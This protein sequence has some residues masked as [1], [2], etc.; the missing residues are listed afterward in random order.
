MAG[1]PEEFIEELKQRNNIV[2]VISRYMPLEKKGRNYWGRCPFHLE[3]T[4]SFSV[5]EVDQFYHCFGCKAGGNL[6]KFVMEMESISFIE[7]I[8][9]VAGWSGME[10]PVDEKDRELVIRQKKEREEMLACMKECAKHYHENLLKS[11]VALEYL[12]NRGIDK[13]MITKFGI[14]FANGYTEIMEHLE[15]KGYKKDMLYRLGIIKEKDG[16]FYDSIGDRIAFPIINMYGEVV[17]FSGRTMKKQVDY[18]K[19]INTGDTPIFSKSKNLFGINLVKKA[20]QTGNL[21]EVIIVEGQTDVIAMHRAGYAGTVASLGTALTVDQ[22]RIIKRLCDNVIICY[23]G[24][25]AGAKATLRGLDILKHENLNVRVASIP[26]NMDP[27]ELLRTQGTR[28]VDRVIEQSIPLVEYKLMVLKNKHNLKEFDGKAKYVE[29][30]INVLQGLDD[31]EA[32]VYIDLIADTTGVYKDF[33]RKKLKDITL[34]LGENNTVA[35]AVIQREVKKDSSMTQAEICVIANILRHSS[36]KHDTN[37]MVELFSG[38]LY[39]VASIANSVTKV[40]E[41][42]TRLDDDAYQEIVGGV[43][44]YNFSENDEVNTNMFEDCLWLIYKDNLLKKQASLSERL[45]TCTEDER[46]DIMA[47]LK[48]IITKINSR[49]VDL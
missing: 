24:D 34:K 17:A 5:N 10:V 32:E 20:K 1:I 9:L 16:R 42:I 45:T 36:G 35:S 22:A 48:T 39:K 25:F 41:F 26:N 7:A 4:A 15:G 28:A 18:A 19:Y 30:A 27:D 44:N 23:D 2:S 31:V 33:L 43:V 3:K 13:D 37:K 38:E 47:E 12:K 49:Q 14:G 40:E 46:D 6:F 29:E 8:K 21:K 11:Q